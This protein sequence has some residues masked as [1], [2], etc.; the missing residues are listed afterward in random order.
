MLA[1]NTTSLFIFTPASAQPRAPSYG[2]GVGGGF[3]GEGSESG[4]VKVR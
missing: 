1:S 4:G 2:G 3:G